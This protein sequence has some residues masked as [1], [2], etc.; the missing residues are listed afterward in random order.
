MKQN[1]LLLSFLAG[2]LLAKAQAPY[3]PVLWMSGITAV[4]PNVEDAGIDFFDIA[5]API[6]NDVYSAGL[7]FSPVNI[8][9]VIVTPDAE[10]GVSTVLI[11]YNSAGEFQWVKNLGYLAEAPAYICTGPGGEVYLTSAFEVETV[12]FGNGVSVLRACLNGCQEMLVARFNANGQAVWA[13]SISAG[14]DAFLEPVG[15]E[16]NASGGVIVAGNYQGTTAYFGPGFDFNNLAA[17]CFFLA[18]YNGNNGTPQGVQFLAPDSEPAQLQHLAINQ[19]GAMV[20]SGYF[21]GLLKFSNGLSLSTTGFFDS[22]VAG[23]QP[24]GAAQWVRIVN[25]TDYYD[26]LGIDVDDS[27][28]AYLAIDA[29]TDLRLD[30]NNILNINTQYAGVVLKVGSSLFSLPVVIPYNTS[31][32]AVM[33]AKLDHW[34]NIYTVGYTTEPIAYGPNKSAVDGCV[35]GFMTGTSNEGLPMW[36]RTVGGVGCEGFVNN[37]YSAGIAF[38]EAGFLYTQGLFNQNFSE[39]GISFPGSGGFIARYNTSIV[40]TNEPLSFIPMQIAPNPNAGSFEL[41]LETEP[42]ANT[43]FQLYN[44]QGSMVYRQVISAQQTEVQADL[45]S[46]VYTVL[47]R[48]GAR[49]ERQKLVVQR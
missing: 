39:E 36:S 43:E 41:Q 5:V 26:I 37:Y 18:V 30:N 48:N 21:S 42:P 31:D 38:D 23:L 14:S 3:P 40:N 29:S 1:F 44:M 13:K 28:N 32:Y 17:G 35:D 16:V 49:M 10:N 27:G 19:N 46:G 7:V 24:T 6:T 15:V 9:G 34:G 4:D 25:S 33:D 20:L 12:N 45:P 2:F 11:K 8:N 22:F 47:L